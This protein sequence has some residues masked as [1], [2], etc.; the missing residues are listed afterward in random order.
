L[1]NEAALLVLGWQIGGRAQ[2]GPIG[3]HHKKL[4][5]LSVRGVLG[6]PRCDLA[7][8]AVAHGERRRLRRGRMKRTLRTHL[9]ALSDSI[10]RSD[11]SNERYSSCREKQ[12]TKNT[13][14]R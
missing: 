3:Q 2:V 1:I 4:G 13:S 9:N 5:L 11:G 14:P 7:W 12:G 8:R 10:G 6:H